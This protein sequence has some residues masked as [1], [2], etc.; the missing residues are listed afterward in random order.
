MFD[1]YTFYFF[2][3]ILK[4]FYASY[5]FNL[6]L[7]SYIESKAPTQLFIRGKHNLS[8]INEDESNS[9]ILFCTRFFI[10]VWL[11]Y[12]H[13]GLIYCFLDW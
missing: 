10:A 9:F 6:K 4:R 11:E 13:G 2:H 7:T 1:N 5:F 3:L 12:N 8:K